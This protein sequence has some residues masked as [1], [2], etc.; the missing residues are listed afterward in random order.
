MDTLIKAIPEHLLALNWFELEETRALSILENLK[1]ELK[2][3]K[4]KLSVKRVH[5]CRV[6]IRRWYSIWEILVNV[7][8]VEDSHKGHVAGFDFQSDSVFANSDPVILAL[9]LQLLQI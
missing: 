6:V 8:A 2:E 9:A 4:G 7:F 5:Q 3:L 1:V